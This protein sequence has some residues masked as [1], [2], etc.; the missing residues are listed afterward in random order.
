[1]VSKGLPKWELGRAV[2]SVERL[3]SNCK[4]VEEQERKVAPGWKNVEDR[5]IR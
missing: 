5:M 1:L 4:N 3:M 2:F